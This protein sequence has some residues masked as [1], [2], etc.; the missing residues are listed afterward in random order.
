[1]IDQMTTNQIPELDNFTGLGFELNQSRYMGRH[2]SEH[3]FGKT[4]FT[5]TLC[6]CDIEKGIAYVILSNRTFPTRPTDATAINKLRAD[7]GEI[8]LA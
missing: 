7:I 1:M 4:G 3:T 8:L 6:I 5:G 2:C